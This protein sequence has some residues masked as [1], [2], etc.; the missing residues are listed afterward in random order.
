[1]RFASGIAT[2][3][4]EQQ[5]VLYNQARGYAASMSSGGAQALMGA[6]LHAYACT[7]LTANAPSEL[8]VCSCLMQ[9]DCFGSMAVVG[10]PLSDGRLTPNAAFAALG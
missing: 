5:A 10:S 4:T 9:K 1:V 2:T 6:A 3:I 7:L 8:N